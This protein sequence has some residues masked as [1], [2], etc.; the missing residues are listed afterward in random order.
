MLMAP[1]ILRLVTGR[2][3]RWIA[4]AYILALPTIAHPAELPQNLPASLLDWHVSSDSPDR[5]TLFPQPV[6]QESL[7]PVEAWRRELTFLLS[8]SR[9]WQP[10]A[11]TAAE[12]LKA[13]HLPELPDLMNTDLRTAIPLEF[14]PFYLPDVY[15]EKTLDDFC[16]NIYVN[17]L[18]LRQS[19]W[20]NPFAIA[21]R[22]AEKLDNDRKFRRKQ[23]ALGALYAYLRRDC[24][25]WG[26]AATLAMLHEQKYLTVSAIAELA[27]PELAKRLPSQ[28]VDVSVGEGEVAVDLALRTRTSF[29]SI[30]DPEH[31]LRA[32]ASRG[33]KALAIADRNR[34]DSAQEAQRVARRLQRQ[35][36][37]PPDFQVIPGEH[38]ETLS[39]SVLGLFIKHRIPDGMTMAKT[40][41]LIHN[42]GGIALLTHPGVAG[43]PKLLRALPFDGY[44]IQ[45]GIFEMYRT[46][47]IL[48]DPALANKT[49]LYASS[50][51]YEQG[52]GLPY[53][54][55]EADSTALPALRDAMRQG[56]SWAAGGLYLPSML[57]VS[58]PPLAKFEDILNSYY[59]GHDYT[60]R[61]LWE[62]LKAGNVQLHTTWDREVRR[63]MGL[64]GLPGGIQDIVNG[65]SP[66][67]DAPKL[68]DISAE[69][70]WFRVTYNHP[71]DTWRLT[72]TLQ[73]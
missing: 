17:S 19:G 67:L 51:P 31:L 63:M 1:G 2:S 16:H 3:S 33:L 8:D 65:D 4:L 14:C 28:L 23:L 37:L 41:D 71:T 7:L 45:P 43:G 57:L 15:P 70:S 48:Y 72:A 44:L 58:M 47:R 60:E 52:V 40:V 59:R 13:S 10:R 73:W 30:A 25:H 69:Y 34:V 68:V 39:G 62:L 42:Q 9:L 56:N 24:E 20:A 46:M 54:I 21:D 5:F 22:Q 61:K 38:I 32:A 29:D 64:G 66:L 55:I 35:G 53:S 11:L 6:R 50:S 26:T 36:K 12:L 27:I 18:L 49:A